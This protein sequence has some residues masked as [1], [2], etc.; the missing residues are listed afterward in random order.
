MTVPTDDCRD[1]MPAD[2]PFDVIVTDPSYGNTSLASDHCVNGWLACT[3]EVAAMDER[4][5]ERI[6]AVLPFHDGD[7]A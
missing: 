3:R 6:A 7:A 4:A 1:F 5:P 2:G